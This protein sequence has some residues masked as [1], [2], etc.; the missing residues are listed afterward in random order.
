MLTP[1]SMYILELLKYVLGNLSPFLVNKGY[2]RFNIINR[3][4]LMISKHSKKLNQ[5]SGHKI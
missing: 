4:V 1:S 5:I 3:I 2:H